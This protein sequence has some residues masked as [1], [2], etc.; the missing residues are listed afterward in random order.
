MEPLQAHRA[1]AGFDGLVWQAGRGNPVASNNFMLENTTGEQRKWVWIDLESGVPALFALNPLA[2]LMFYLP[3]SVHHRRWL[4]DDVDICK[5]R[6]WLDAHQSDII[7]AIGDTAHASLLQHID[8]LDQS[9]HEWRSL[10][11]HQ[12]GI[13][14]EHSQDHITAAQASWYSSRPLHWYAASSIALARRSI[15]HLV[16]KARHLWTW[17]RAFPVRHTLH[18]TGRYMT[19]SKFRW[20]VARWFIGKSIRSWSRRGFLDSSAATELGHELRQ[21]EASAYLTDFSVHLVIKPFV[22]GFQW[23]VLPALWLSGTINEMVFALLL[24]GGGPIGRTAYTSW[25]MVQATWMQMRK[26]WVALFVGVLPVVG[27]LAY[28]LQLVY[29]STDSSGALARFIVY[30]LA[31][32]I[33]RAVPIWGG[34]DSRVEHFFNRWCD[35]GVRWLVRLKTGKPQ[36][37]ADSCR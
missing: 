28:P 5:L 37:A 7:H 34:A 32:R 4:F 20:G 10:R 11:R 31:A 29:S 18:R 14:Y 6:S 30:D 19:S 36:S 33:G 15:R 2:T 23:G 25:R 12:R 35:I 21:D 27:N 16:T 8:E 9:Q 1:T 13:E 3:K 26:P 17:I 24:V 22:K